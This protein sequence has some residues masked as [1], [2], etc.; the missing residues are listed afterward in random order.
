MNINWVIKINNLDRELKRSRR[1]KNISITAGYLLGATLI[2]WPAQSYFSKL[3]EYNN[4]INESSTEIIFEW[5]K[6]EHE[7]KK[8][9]IDFVEALKNIQSV[10]VYAQNEKRF[11]SITQ[12]YDS[13]EAT[14][15]KLRPKY[16]TE[17]RNNKDYSYWTNKRNEILNREDSKAKLRLAGYISGIILLLGLGAYVTKDVG[18][19]F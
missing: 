11:D 17:L 14:L 15:E 4:K 8:T 13:L 9:N 6:K 18:R 2:V 7:L 3:Q 19:V 12:Q 10:K 16:E 1:I 5:N